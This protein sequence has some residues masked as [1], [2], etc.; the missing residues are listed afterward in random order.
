MS[1]RIG[2][3]TLP[4]KRTDR[5]LQK[6]NRIDYHCCPEKCKKNYKMNLADDL[7]KKTS[8]RL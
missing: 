6:N 3:K 5:V 4:E 8:E 7:R 2:W 1:C